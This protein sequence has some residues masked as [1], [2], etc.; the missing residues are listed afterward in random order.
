MLMDKINNLNSFSG[1]TLNKMGLV[2]IS[3]YKLGGVGFESSKKKVSNERFIIGNLQV[4]CHSTGS[5]CVHLP[6]ITV[7]GFETLQYRPQP[8]FNSF[9]ITLFRPMAKTTSLFPPMQCV[10]VK[11]RTPRILLLLPRRFAV[12][13]DTSM[14]SL[15]SPKH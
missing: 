13:I 14:L 3:N 1:S 4:C 9:S 10:A 5:S 8:L 6:E 15:R 2:W 7:L 11:F 12:F